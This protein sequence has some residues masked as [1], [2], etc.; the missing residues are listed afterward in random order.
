M[1]FRQNPRRSSRSSTC[2]QFGS[3]GPATVAGRATPRTPRPACSDIRR[4][5]RS[6]NETVCLTI[7]PL[8][9]FS[10]VVCVG[11]WKS[12]DTRS[13]R[14]RVLASSQPA[15]STIFSRKRPG[16]QSATSVR[17]GAHVTK[18]GE[19]EEKDDEGLELLLLLLLLPPAAPK[20]VLEVFAFLAWLELMPKKFVKLNQNCN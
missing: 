1:T 2:V 4:S 13:R 10:S 14:L 9:S 17:F 19:D 15:V 12:L 7:A 11:A 6:T 3:G 8:S 16:K 5:A 20:E 18:T